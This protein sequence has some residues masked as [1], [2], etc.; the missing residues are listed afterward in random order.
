MIGCPTSAITAGDQAP[1]GRSALLLILALVLLLRVPFLNQAI[2]GDDPV[3]LAEA[4]HALVDPLHPDNSTY[5]FRGETVD[6]R[7]LSHPPMDAWILAGLLAIFGDVKEVPFHAAYI[8]FSL[9]AAWAM[10]WL[11]RRFSPQPLWAALLFLAVPTFVVNGNSLETDLP[12]LAF[13]M[14]AVALFCA[15]KLL[16]AALA[17]IL[18]A[19]TA[20]QGVFLTPILAVY[21]WLFHRRSVARWLTIWTAPAAI[22]AWQLYERSTTGAMPAAVLAGYFR[23]YG[24]QALEAKISNALALFIHSW[25]MVFPAL[26]AAALPLAWRRRR[27]PETIFLLA[28]IVLFFGGSVAVLFAGSARYLLP[29][30]AP[31]A[32]LASRLSRRWLAAGFA[33]QMTLSL[34]LAAM[35]YQHWGAVRAYAAGLAPSIENH[36]VWVDD[37]WGLRHYMEQQGALPL[38]QS[39]RL[40]AGDI[41]VSGELSRAVKISAPTAPVVPPV[42]IRPGIPLRII[43]LETRSGYSSAS[44]DHLFPFGIST[45]VIDR[46]RAVEVVERHPTLSY[47]PMTAPEA[48]TQIAGGIY[49]L[50]DHSFRWMSRLATVALKSPGTA[51]ALAVSFQ[52]PAQS[53]AR[54]VTL[55]IDGKEVASQV[56]AAPGDYTLESPPLLPATPEVLVEIEVDRTFTA[57]PD[58]R[59]LGIVLK[60]IGF[61][62]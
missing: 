3:Y 27:E 14:A 49:D 55:R 39:E 18:A 54:R 33:I 38:R 42:E 20:Y 59:E 48:A 62:P 41:I 10:W 22:A 56:Y 9:M 2:Q 44:F 30:A 8:L 25:F 60:G 21:V 26:A 12:F 34:G 61:R 32:L 45:G 53:P 7:G 1:T 51:A 29:M 35:N 31:V 50:E 47:L 13:W 6:Q 58:V 24:F 57:S 15:G 43:G 11:G 17:M 5:V 28:W 19:L 37:E 4:S 16:P 46:L 36:R 52:I 23:S 40:R